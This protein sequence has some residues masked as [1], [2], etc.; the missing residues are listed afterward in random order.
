MFV[1]AALY[2][3]VGHGGASAYL[4][5][6]ALFSVA[7]AT[8][9]PTAL[10]L[11]IIVASFVSFRYVRA[12]LFS[13]RVL[14]PFVLGAIPA[15]FVGGTIQI[16][17]EYYRPLVG[18]LLFLAAARLLWPDPN[19]VRRT[20]QNPPIFAGVA[21]GAG[22]GLLSGLTG[23]GGGI[24]LS[25]LLLL[26]GWCEAR[27]ALGVGAVFVLCNSIAGLSGNLAS[28]R[29][30]PPELPI[31]A[32]VVLAGACVGTYLG[33]NRFARGAILKALAL[34]LIIAGIKLVAGP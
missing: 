28:M 33:I 11:N 27:V 8:M 23:T 29:S 25:P 34:V 32:V 14:W 19:A 5:L 3:S 4:A 18:A 30:L 1:V 21:G 17:S 2:T 24:F 22:I 16:Q 13:W 12:G 20:P 26:L 31:Y 10:A 9:R 15:A 6:M 7:P